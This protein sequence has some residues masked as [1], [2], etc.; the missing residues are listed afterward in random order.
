VA[1]LHIQSASSDHCFVVMS[2]DH[3]NPERTLVELTILTGNWC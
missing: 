2:S 1:V 3:N